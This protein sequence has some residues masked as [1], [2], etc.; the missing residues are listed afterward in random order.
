MLRLSQR[1]GTCMTTGPEALAALETCSCAAG[2]ALPRAGNKA[3]ISDGGGSHALR[4]R[5]PS[6]FGEIMGGSG[7]VLGPGFRRRRLVIRRT[8]CVVTRPE[9]ATAP[10]FA[11]PRVGGHPGR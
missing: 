11:G 3:S 4:E 7:P 2:G 9:G 10:R 6:M 5:R 8:Q 1:Q